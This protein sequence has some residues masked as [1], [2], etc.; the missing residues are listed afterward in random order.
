M[1]ERQIV[2]KIIHNFVEVNEYEDYTNYKGLITA[3]IEWKNEALTLTDASQQ[4]ELLDAFVCTM[5]FDTKHGTY[6]EDIDYFLEAY[7]SV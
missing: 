5:E 2:N 3:L 7:K 4:R 6:Q 1:N